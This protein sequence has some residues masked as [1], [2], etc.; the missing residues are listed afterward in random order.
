MEGVLMIKY[1]RFRHLG[2][3]YRGGGG[4]RGR[5]QG[6]GYR[7]EKNKVRNGTENNVI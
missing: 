2:I 5:L 7:G 4:Y 6:V 1:H 3:G